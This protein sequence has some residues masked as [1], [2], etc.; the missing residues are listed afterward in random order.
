MAKFLNTKA[1]NYCIESL[2]ESATNRCIIISPYLKLS[3][4]LMQSLKTKDRMGL[5]AHIIYGK[6][7]LQ[8]DEVRWLAGLEFM[9]L[10]FCSNL[11][12]KCYMN[13]YLCV[14]TSMNLYGFSQANNIEMG[15]LF[16]SDE[17]AELYR[18]AYR[19][20]RRI[21]ELSTDARLEI[22][23]QWGELE[24]SNS[25]F[26]TSKLAEKL[27]IRSTALRETLV[28]HGYLENYDG[29]Y[30]LTP[31]G[32]A[33]GGEFRFSPKYGPYFLWPADFNPDS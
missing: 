10:G 18:D 17:D 33:V 32:K 11:H 20:A 3:E 31:K 1:I 13:D 6:A 28:T 22:Q 15:I 5:D 29:K 21:I 25:K 23:R 2:I 7:E 16:R 4:R 26:T 14:V 30:T 24:K 8:Q 9:R 27:G 19:E 12:A